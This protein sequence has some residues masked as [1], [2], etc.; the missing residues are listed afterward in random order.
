MAT[1]PV[2]LTEDQLK[3]K[4]ER[5]LKKVGKMEM[6]LS[7]L[8]MALSENPQF[9]KFLEFQKAVADKTTEVKKN[10]ETQMI[11]NGIKSLTIDSY[12]KIT[13]VERQ[14]IAVT[15]ESK[16]PKKYFVKTINKKALN[17]DY[18]LTGELLEGTE[19]KI[20]RF[21]KMTPKKEK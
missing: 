1:E 11:D 10:L 3:A 15:D 5:E 13:I 7:E 6:E 16:L 2:I 4:A 19:Q 9:V 12:G 18:K 17:D 21:I 8:Q 20:T 14:D